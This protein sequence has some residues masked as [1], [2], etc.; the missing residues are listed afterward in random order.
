MLLLG[1]MNMH[2]KKFSNL[3]LIFFQLDLCSFYTREANLFSSQKYLLKKVKGKRGRS[4]SYKTYFSITLLPNRIHKYLKLKRH[5]YSHL[6]L[7][8]ERIRSIQSSNISDLYS[9]S[10]ELEKLKLKT[11]NNLP[12]WIEPNTM[13]RC[14]F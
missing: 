11:I 6:F 3:M 12:A 7:S 2:K 14:Y 9:Q 4:W 10:L 1:Y 13:A 8:R 5:C